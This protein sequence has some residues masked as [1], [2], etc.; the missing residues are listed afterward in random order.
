[1][2][3]VNPV[4]TNAPGSISSITCFRCGEKGHLASTAEDRLKKERISEAESRREMK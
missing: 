4:V 2:A 1:V 3:Q